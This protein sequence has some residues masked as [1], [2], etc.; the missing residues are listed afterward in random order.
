MKAA[1]GQEETSA[2][3]EARGIDALLLRYSRWRRARLTAMAEM[4]LSLLGLQTLYLSACILLDGVVLPWIVTLLGGGF[5]YLLFV[6]LLLP[7]LAAESVLYRRVKAPKT[8][9]A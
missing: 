2:V 3:P 5:S 4:P 1:D 6:L 7:T 8:P 9:S